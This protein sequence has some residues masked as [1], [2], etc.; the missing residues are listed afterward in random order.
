VHA[1]NNAIWTADNIGGKRCHGLLLSVHSSQG[2]RKRNALLNLF[3]SST[4][5]PTMCLGHVTF[6]QCRR[7][8]PFLALFEPCHRNRCLIR[9]ILFNAHLEIWKTVIWYVTK[10]E[11]TEFTNARRP[12]LFMSLPFQFGNLLATLSMSFY[13]SSLF[14]RPNLIGKPRYLHGN[15]VMVA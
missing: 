15:P 11:S 4:P 12:A 1:L 10:E 2:H 6:F 5:R 13:S 9:S 3:K 8:L 7:S 14:S